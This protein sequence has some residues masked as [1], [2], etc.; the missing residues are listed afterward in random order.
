MIKKVSQK[1]NFEILAKLLNDSFLTV[2]KEFGLTKENCPTNNAFISAEDL[3]SQSDDNREFYCLWENE[4]PYGFIAIEKSKREEETYYIEKVAVH[5]DHRHRKAGLLLM[6]F[7]T[8]RIK[9]L[10]GKKISI[11]V[12]DT[13]TRLKE[14]Y[15][16]QG[17]IQTGVRVFEH[18]PFDVCYM[19]KLL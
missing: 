12:I 19:E 11:G 5:P 7:A 9:N 4:M 17:F 3:R 18:L 13:N 15:R 14:W 10:G 6:N 16:Q 1:N 8:D 2:A